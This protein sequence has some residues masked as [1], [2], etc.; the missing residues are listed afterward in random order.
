MFVQILCTI[1]TKVKEYIHVR[2]NHPGAGS[3]CSFSPISQ[4]LCTR[5]FSSPSSLDEAC[6]CSMSTVGTYS[7]GKVPWSSRTGRDPMERTPRSSREP[8]P[9]RLGRCV[10]LSASGFIFLRILIHSGRKTGRLTQM[11]VM[12]ASAAVQ[13]AGF[14][15]VSAQ[16]VKLGMAPRHRGLLV[17]HHLQ[18]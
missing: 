17:S 1:C 14:E 6:V 9:K 12:D 5:V 16:S 3:F 8:R 2:A 13:I 10:S 11:M 7:D 4:L 15:V 18:T